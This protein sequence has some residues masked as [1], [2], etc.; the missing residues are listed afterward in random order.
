MHAANEVI[1][2]SFSLPRSM[3]SVPGVLTAPGAYAAVNEVSM[4][5]VG[6]HDTQPLRICAGLL[7]NT[8]AYVY[9]GGAV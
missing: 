3:F 4:I 7:Q 9:A 6:Q 2:G 5:N 8:R 1:A